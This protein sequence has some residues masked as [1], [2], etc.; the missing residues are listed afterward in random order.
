MREGRPTSAPGLASICAGA[1]K[2]ARIA[3]PGPHLCRDWPGANLSGAA[4]STAAA[5]RL[6]GDES[7]EAPLRASR[8]QRRRGARRRD[9][10]GAQIRRLS[11]PGSKP[12]SKAAQGYGLLGVT[13]PTLTY[14]TRLQRLAPALPNSRFYRACALSLRRGRPQWYPNIAQARRGAEYIGEQ[15]RTEQSAH[16]QLRRPS[17]ADIESTSTLRCRSVCVPVPVCGCLRIMW[18]AVSS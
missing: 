8:T 9:R 11:P 13:H 1:D 14:S 17:F 7:R 18:C 5:R 12:K 4:C 16:E 3:G 6:A 15:G 10:H 2:V